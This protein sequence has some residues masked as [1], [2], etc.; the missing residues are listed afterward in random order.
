MNGLTDYRLEITS[1]FLSFATF[2][3]V[4]FVVLF[5]SVGAFTSL[6]GAAVYSILCLVSWI[7]YQFGRA[8]F[9]ANLVNCAM[10]LMLFWII[11]LSGGFHS[12]FLI[13]LAVPPVVIGLLSDLR[14]AMMLVGLVF[15]YVVVLGFVP[16]YLIAVSEID[17]HHMDGMD[18]TVALISVT[19][20][21]ATMIFFSLQ[22]YKALILLIEAAEMRERTDSL[23]GILNRGGFNHAV[24]GLTEHKSDQAG[25]LILFD[26]DDFKGINDSHGHL[27]GDQ[28]L[29]A[30]AT[31]A[32]GTVRAGDI[33]A[34][35]GGD[36]FA[37]ILPGANHT[38]AVEVSVRIKR[39]IDDLILTSPAE[40]DV[41]VTVSIGVATC[42]DAAICEV[43]PMMHLADQALY[44]AKAIAERLSIKRLLPSLE[45]KNV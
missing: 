25:A 22:N 2:L 32:A 9:A 36:E 3:S 29:K 12:P 33:V 30:I 27:F 18:H 14:W 40:E 20:A 37:V 43:E 13:W 11:A 21:L 15:T 31:V 45:F 16:E 8:T 23:T 26:V 41:S 35:I 38:D 1:S 28:V 19:G 44:E 34:R 42:E 6:L 5:F 7:F 17:G 4:A 39:V 24:L 10:L